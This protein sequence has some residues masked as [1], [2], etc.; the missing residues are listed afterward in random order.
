MDYEWDAAK[1]AKNLRKHGIDLTD[2]IAALED[3]NR[4]EEIDSRFESGEERIR[5]LGMAVRNVL[6]VVV[7]LRDEKTC[8]I[9]SARRATR[10]EQ[11]RYYA[12]DHKAW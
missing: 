8:R 5:V 3:P 2:S 7:T 9:I 6:F 4:L 10:H 11:D 1:A 12:G